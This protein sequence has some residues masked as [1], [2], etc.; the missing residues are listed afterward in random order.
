[1]FELVRHNIC[2]MHRLC[3]TQKMVG[4]GSIFYGMAG[5]DHSDTMCSGIQRE[6]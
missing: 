4:N 5:V 1:M 6:S 3:W 2:E